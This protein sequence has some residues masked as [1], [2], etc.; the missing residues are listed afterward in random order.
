[1]RFWIDFQIIWPFDMHIKK[2]VISIG[3]VQI[4]QVIKAKVEFSAHPVCSQV[5]FQEHHGFFE[6]L[7]CL[8]FG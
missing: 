7:S 1:M 5:I 2:F 3:L 6:S 4:F 8:V